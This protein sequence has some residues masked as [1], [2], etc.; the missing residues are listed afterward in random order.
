M[1]D[2]KDIQVLREMLEEFGMEF[3]RK[4]AGLRSEIK[5]DLEILRT[6]IRDDIID[7]IEDNIQPQCNRLN[8]RVTRLERIILT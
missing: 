7:V 6:E 1:L 2:A 5:K 4:L 8:A 3:D